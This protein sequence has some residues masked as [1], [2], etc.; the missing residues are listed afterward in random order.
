MKNL[1][2]I[3]LFFLSQLSAAQVSLNNKE[4]DKEYQHLKVFSD[5]LYAI[6][7]AYVKEVSTERLIQG[8]VRGMMQELDPHSHF[9]LANQLKTFKKE[10]K[11]QFSGL[12]VE[13]AIKNKQLIIISVLENSPASKAGMK[14]GQVILQINSKKT[15]GLNRMEISKLLESRRGKKF[16]II[17]KDLDSNKNHQMQLRTELISFKSIMHK[18][19]GNQSL[20]IR[21]NAFTGRTLREMRKVINKYKNLKGLILDLRGNPGGLFESAIQVAG[22]FIKEGTIVSIKGRLKDYEQVFQA[23]SSEAFTDFPMIV[24]I[25]NYSASAAEIL[26]G[27]LKENKRAMLFGRKSFG[28]GSVQSLIHLDQ[29]N[30]VKLTVA[31]YYTPDGNSIDEKGIKPHIKLKKPVSS[32]ESKPVSFTGKE[33]TDFHQAISFLKMFKHKHFNPVLHQSSDP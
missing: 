13:L 28:K 6:E 19:I 16:T 3:F 12:G 25:D 27:A 7:K 17:V 24:L 21:I 1:F 9:L 32:N 31:H 4:M 26:A 33:D 23:H 22:L 5:V 2:S 10:A 18:D 30:A 20:Y 15:T 29:G 8:A 11:G 14:A